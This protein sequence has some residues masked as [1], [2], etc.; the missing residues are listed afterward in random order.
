MICQGRLWNWNATSARRRRRTKGIVPIR[1]TIYWVKHDWERRGIKRRGTNA[2]MWIE[3]IRQAGAM[4]TMKRRWE[5]VG[6]RFMAE[7][8]YCW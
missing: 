3:L 5:R 2:L 1:V 6:M 4:A 7:V 8:F